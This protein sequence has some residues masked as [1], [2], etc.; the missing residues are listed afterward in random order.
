MSSELTRARIALFTV[1]VA[2]C[3]GLL[4]L[5]WTKITLDRQSFYGVL[6]SV[7]LLFALAF[8]L[9][10]RGMILLRGL[11]DVLG[12]AVLISY[13][14][15]VWSYTAI[16]FALPL[17]DERLLGLDRSLGFDWLAFAHVIDGIPLLAAAL[18]AAYQSF[19]YQLLLLPLL[20]VVLGYAPR[21]YML[22]AAFGLLCMSA[23]VISIWFPALGAHVA[24]DVDPAS[25]ENLNPYFG[26]A[27]LK[28]FHAVRD[29]VSFSLSADRAAGILTFPS[30]HAGTA[31]LCA[32][33]ASAVRVLKWPMVILNIG[34]AVSAISHGSH[35]FV[36]ILAGIGIAILI[37]AVLKACIRGRIASLG[38]YP[39]PHP[40]R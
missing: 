17:A 18:F 16:S 22:V 6:P 20:L 13:A 38:R 34:M 14:G 8:Y 35:Y 39:V 1:T 9:H 37:V 28:Q 5:P 15:L 24:L 21:G 11:M 23:S 12:C 4:V 29:S 27:F 36:D 30:V 7:A 10:W 3:C 40:V 32:W 33:A 26:Y 31:F 19:M 2:A 25:L